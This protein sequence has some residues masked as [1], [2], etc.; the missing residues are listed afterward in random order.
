ME[1]LKYTLIDVKTLEDLRESLN[2]DNPDLTW[3]KERL[4]SFFKFNEQY[5]KYYSKEQ[6]RSI[7]QKCNEEG[8]IMFFNDEGICTQSYESFVSQPAEGVLYDLNRDI[9]SSLTFFSERTIND[10]GAAM[11]IKKLM[12]ENAELK[13]E[14]EVL[15]TKFEA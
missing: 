11:V 6:V 12:E 8:K 9:A 1:G 3:I 15:T 2:K 4:A 14:I 13:K 5:E 7:M 10:I